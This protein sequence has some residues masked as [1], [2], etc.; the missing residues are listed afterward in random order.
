MHK[1]REKMLDTIIV[2]AGLKN[3]QPFG[4]F[5]GPFAKS[6]DEPDNLLIIER[7]G[8]ETLRVLGFQ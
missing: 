4:A 1:K 6:D 5:L 7:R 8:I 3:R 2:A